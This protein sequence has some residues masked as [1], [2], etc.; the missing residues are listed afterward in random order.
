M[1]ISKQL[2]DLQAQSKAK[3]P[4]TEKPEMYKKTRVKKIKELLLDSWLKPPS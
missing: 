3:K 1:V 4:T 2:Q